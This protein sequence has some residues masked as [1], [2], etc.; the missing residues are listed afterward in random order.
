[1]LLHRSLI[2]S[3]RFEHSKHSTR[4]FNI[5]LKLFDEIML[6][7]WAMR[8]T[9][10]QLFFF[11]T[12]KTTFAGTPWRKYWTAKWNISHNSIIMSLYSYDVIIKSTG[13]ANSFQPNQKQ[14]LLVVLLLSP[15][16]FEKCFLQVLVLLSV[17]NSFLNNSAAP[18]LN[19]FWSDLAVLI[20][21][22][23]EATSINRCVS[24]RQ[25]GDLSVLL[26]SIKYFKDTVIEHRSAQKNRPIS[27]L[28]RRI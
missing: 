10:K 28:K 20:V 2:E 18:H 16:W 14:S 21:S 9:T 7:R 5:L 19:E 26:L 4:T 13:S 6:A 11:S 27:T 24:L 8:F 1:M 3:I 23:F 22:N 15:R 17:S 25:C 12:R